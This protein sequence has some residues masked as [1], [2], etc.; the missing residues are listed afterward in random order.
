MCGIVGYLGPKAPKDIIVDGLKQ[1][2]Y[3]GYDSAGVAI[4]HQG[5]LKRVRAQGKLTNLEKK[6]ETEKFDG[7]LGIG[8]TRWATHGAPSETNA[9]PH[10]VGGV[11][12]VHNG[13]IEN[14]MEIRERIVAE[15][16]KI[17]SETDSELVAHLLSQEV[18]E[19]GDLFEAALN[20]VPQLEGAYS[21]LA[22]WEEKPE[23]MVA[24][25]NGPPLIVGRGEGEVIVASDIQAIVKHTREVVYLEDHEIAFIDGKSISFFDLKGNPIKKEISHID[26]NR[27]SA[28]KGGYS[29]YMLKEIY[30]QPR[31]VASVIEPH[32][33]RDPLRIDMKELTFGSS[34]TPADDVFKRIDRIYIVACGTSF[35]AGLTAEYFFEKLA[36][37]PVE[38]ELASEFRY[39]EPILSPNGLMITISQSGETADTLAALRLAKKMGATT[40]SICNVQRSTIDREADGQLYMRCGTEIGVAS[41]KAFTSTQTL[42]ALLGVYVGRIRGVLSVQQEQEYLGN[43][44]ALPSQMETVLNHAKFF[45]SAAMALKNAKGFLYL[46]R[47]ANYPI[48]LEGALKLKELAY[49]HAEGY[50][51]G[52]MKH[53]PIALIDKNM[54][55]VVV[56]PK[57]DVYEKTV[58]NLEEVRARGAQ[59]IS[60][61]T[62][63]DHKLE[64]VSQHYLALPEASWFMNPMMAV[65]PLQLLS[66]YVASALGH[67]VDQP[68]NLAKSVTVE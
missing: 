8:H 45:E 29:H 2:E 13:I 38:V 12:I 36:K 55:V 15:G 44:L 49:M 25:K 68:R 43:L 53:G 4:L 16:G 65:I 40:L 14:Y 23:Q 22:V 47:G 37:V 31:A 60:I 42:L 62:G 26:W 20:V 21:I 52:E 41:T 28:E 5:S 19:T 61:G 50:A 58:S 57:D 24:F 35:Y 56:A 54:I 66:F 51:A 46:G 59:V 6:L 33:Q 30:E 11:S 7:H 64:Q 67:D 27:E 10:S 63:V 9:H 34:K 1:L 3:R 17:K 18:R 39:R 48:A 32:I